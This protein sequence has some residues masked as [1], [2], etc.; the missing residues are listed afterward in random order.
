MILP[1]KDLG[2]NLINM[3]QVVMVFGCQRDPFFQKNR[4]ARE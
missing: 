1:E 3:V 2:A 4:Q